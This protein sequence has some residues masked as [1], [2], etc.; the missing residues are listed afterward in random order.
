[1]TEN[2][3]RDIKFGLRMISKNP[4]FSA[5]II[6]TVV[7]SVGV[8]GGVFT[9]VNSVL[10]RPLAYKD[11]NNLVV[12]WQTQ[13]QQERTPVSPGDFKDLES[14]G[15][16]FEALAAFRYQNLN[17]TGGGEPERI[18]CLNVS[19]GFFPLLGTSLTL[20]RN[21][22]PEEEQPGKNQ[23][24]ILTHGVWERRF[25]SD[26]G[27]IGREIKLND[28][29]YSVIGVL[30][31]DFEFPNGGEL[32]TP[33]SLGSDQWKVRNTHMLN[34]IGRL[35]P[36]VTVKKA[37][38]ALAVIAR[39]L[40][41][42]FPSTNSNVGFRVISLYEQVVGGARSNLL[43]LLGAV[44]F[45]L[46]IACANISNLLLSRATTRHR[47]VAIR[48]SLGATRLSLIRQL[49]VETLLLFLAGGGAGIFVSVWL[50]RLLI[51]ASP[52]NIPRAREVGIDVWVLAFMLLVSLAAGMITGLVPALQATKTD[53]S[54]LLKEGA[55][56]TAGS[57]HQQRTRNLLAGLEIALALVLLIGSGL[58]IKSLLRLENVDPGF[59]PKNVL[60]AQISLPA[61]KYST[62]QQQANFFKQALDRVESLP[63]VQAASVTTSLP[64]TGPPNSTGFILEG[65]TL[66]PDEEKPVVEYRQVGPDYFKAV[67]IPLLKGRQFNEFDREASQP[68]IIINETL[69]RTF[70]H[71]DDP[72]GRKIGLSGPPDWREIIGVVG[73]VRNGG[74]ESKS[75]PEAYI[76]YLQNTS[77]Y[78]GYYTM[79][80]AILSADDPKALAPL[81]RSKIYE[82]DANQPVYNIISMD[83]I[84][85]KSVSQPRFNMY[86]FGSFAAIALLLS[87]SGIYGVISYSVT[88]RRGEIGIRMALGARRLDILKLVI[89]QAAAISVA[90]IAAGLAAAL[91]LTRILSSFLYEVS[92]TDA[93]TFAIVSMGLFCVSLLASYVPARQA[94]SVNPII[95][96]RAE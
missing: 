86:L 68:V 22:A 65:Q 16:A 54:E 5:V 27:I 13:P 10:L 9:I 2:L 92:S 25:G 29:P 84:I 73:D 56:G 66:G 60:T 72:V 8:N 48:T 70:F 61:S 14:Q 40:E 90:G 3:F 53:L 71:D 43:I 41:Q 31:S 1:M 58:M 24:V 47:E 96:L 39:Q 42:Q 59:N 80:L 64:M 51:S 55:R 37:Q 76:P 32:W 91:A 78:L 79:S 89:G 23:V 93:Q 77:P 7:L 81:I 88:Q 21:F 4:G 6:L 95:A 82:V 63:G 46:L 69:A 62:P 49:T 20:G 50:T 18:R 11:S 30:P 19:S 75:A 35:K 36:G 52:G 28:K 33:L 38:T 26:P 94:T 45:V 85:S 57:R 15:E 34:V 67:G 17:L 83:Q 12:V 44:A 87:T 74:L